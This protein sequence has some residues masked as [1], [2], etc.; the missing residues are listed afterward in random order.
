MKEELK[1]AYHEAYSLKGSTE[2]MDFIGVMEKNNKLLYFYQDQKGNYWYRAKY[3]TDTGIISE[4]EHVFERIPESIKREEK[5]RK[6]IAWRKMLKKS[7][8]TG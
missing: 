4:T 1:K 3:R 7:R 8:M 5:A 2:G 6:E